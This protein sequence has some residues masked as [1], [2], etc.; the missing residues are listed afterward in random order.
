MDKSKTIIEQSLD[1]VCSLGSNNSS[2]F[3]VRNMSVEKVAEVFLWSETSEEQLA[4][5][6]DDLFGLEPHTHVSPD[7]D[8]WGNLALLG[9]VVKL[10]EQGNL[11]SLIVRAILLKLQTVNASP[12][13]FSTFALAYSRTLSQPNISPED[14]RGYARWIIDHYP[15]GDG[16]SIRKEMAIMALTSHLDLPVEILSELCYSPNY[17]SRMDAAKHPSCPEEDRIAVVLMGNTKNE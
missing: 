5:M 6:A 7:V 10:A 17:S 16:V 9:N 13:L 15:I 14:L 2:D 1:E 3:C 4:V 8:R 11:P 12:T